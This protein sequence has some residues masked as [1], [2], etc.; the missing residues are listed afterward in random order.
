[1]ASDN[2][3]ASSGIAG[4]AFINQVIYPTEQG[5]ENPVYFQMEIIPFKMQAQLRHWIH[6]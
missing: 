5:E 6:P 4:A 1:L 3:K 2:S